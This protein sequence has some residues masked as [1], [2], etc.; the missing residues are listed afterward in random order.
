MEFEGRL[1]QLALGKKMEEGFFH[2]EDEGNLLCCLAEDSCIFQV[3]N[4]FAVM[5][6]K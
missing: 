4:K 2:P 6:F 5:V 3:V 1:F